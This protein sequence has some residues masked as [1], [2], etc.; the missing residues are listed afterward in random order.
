MCVSWCVFLYYKLNED[1]FLLKKSFYNAYEND[2]E[3]VNSEKLF[4]GILPAERK[5]SHSRAGC[6][7]QLSVCKLFKD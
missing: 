1:I 6:D 7:C 4:D 2:S 3:E 5:R